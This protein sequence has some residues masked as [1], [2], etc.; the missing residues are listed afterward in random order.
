ME[1]TSGRGH[2]TRNVEPRERRSL[3]VVLQDDAVVA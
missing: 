2:R 1:D 3:F